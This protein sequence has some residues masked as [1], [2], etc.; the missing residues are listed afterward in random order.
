MRRWLV[1]LDGRPDHL[2]VVS[3]HLTYALAVRARRMRYGRHAGRKVL[4]RRASWYRRWRS[5]DPTIVRGD[6]VTYRRLSPEG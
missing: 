1:L 3:R 6:L 4:V 2:E 5:W